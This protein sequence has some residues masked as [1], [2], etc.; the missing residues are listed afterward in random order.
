MF[1]KGRDIRDIIDKYVGC[2]SHKLGLHKINEI[3]TSPFKKATLW[4][5]VY[6]PVRK[7]E[8]HGLTG[9]I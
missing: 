2:K 9:V 5:E 7:P 6:D 3:Y 8:Y 1:L 4:F